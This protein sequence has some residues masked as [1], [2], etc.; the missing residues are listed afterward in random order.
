MV[1]VVPQHHLKL[2]V[3]ED[4]VPKFLLHSDNLEQLG[5]NLD[6][7]ETPGG[8]VVAVV[9]D[10]A[11]VHPIHLVVVLVDLMLV[12]VVAEM[13]V[14]HLCQQ[15]LVLLIPEVVEEVVVKDMLHHQP[16]TLPLLDKVVEV[17]QV[18]F[19]SHTTPNK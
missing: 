11:E 7:M 3:M 16:A 2:A 1:L 12:V 13:Q 10:H 5:V 6:L 17:D 9:E 14:L 15:R 19:S 8:S 4:W 18:L